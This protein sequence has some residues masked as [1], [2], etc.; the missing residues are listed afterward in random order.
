MINMNLFD[1]MIKDIL[2]QLSHI[3]AADSARLEKPQRVWKD[4]GEHHMILGKEMAY[5]LGGQGTLGLS[6]C[7]Y[8]TEPLLLPQGVYLYGED[9]AQIRTSRSFARIVLA[10]LEE[11]DDEQALYRKFREVDYVRYH[12]HPE[13]YMVR[14]S[15]VSQ[16][17]PVRI[18]KKA[19]KDKISFADI[20]QMYLERYQRILQVKNVN[21]IF[22]THREFD[23]DAL[24]ETLR[25]AEQ[26]TQSLNHIFKGLNMDCGTCSLKAVCDQVEGLRELHF[27]QKA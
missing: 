23:Y 5:E 27:G 10:H 7:L 16:R 20:G 18:G 6:G 15:P 2:G 12:I 22:V 17:E 4:A 24:D 1:D 19:L 25:R 11:S 26:I 13:G 21:V 9:M 3:L 14:I 8:T